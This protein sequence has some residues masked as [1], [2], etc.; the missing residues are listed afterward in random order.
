M[1]L[2]HNGAISHMSNNQKKKSETMPKRVRLTA[3]L[4]L[5][6]YDAIVQLQR[7]HRA[8]TGRALPIW[9]II[10]TAVKAYAEKQNIQVG[11]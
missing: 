10:D 5:E 2:L 7:Q 1:V 11:E 9:K 3:H 8:K 6:A 4:S